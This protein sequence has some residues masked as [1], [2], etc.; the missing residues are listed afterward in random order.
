[1][2]RLS[3]KLPHYFDGFLVSGVNQTNAVLPAADTAT[4]MTSAPPTANI[5]CFQ[6]VAERLW[7]LSSKSL[8]SQLRPSTCGA[9]HMIRGEIS[10]KH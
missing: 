5:F 7:R 6:L 9:L 3:S 10:K 8:A 2:N 4:N 1:M